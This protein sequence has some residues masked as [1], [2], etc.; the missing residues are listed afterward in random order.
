MKILKKIRER[1]LHWFIETI[2]LKITFFLNNILYYFFSILPIND[3][4]IIFESEGDLSDNSFALYDYMLKNNY[5]EKYKFIWAVDDIKNARKFKFPQTVFINRKYGVF[6]LKR[7]YYL[8]TSR[9][10]IFDHYNILSNVKKRRNQLVLNLWH[11]VGYKAIKNGK[12]VKEKSTFDFF[13]TLSDK[14]SL[15]F[16]K[17][18][19]E[20]DP[21]KGVVLGYPRLDYFFRDNL[22]G[23]KF[24]KSLVGDKNKVLLWMPTFRQSI[25][26]ELSEEYDYSETGLPIV[27]TADAMIK[28]NDY[29]IKENTT[30]I[31]KIHHLQAKLPIFKTEF[32]NIILMSD[33]DLRDNNVQLYQFISQ[34]DGLITDYSSIAIDYLLLDRPIIFTL[35]DYEEYEKHRG[36]YKKDIK[37]Y[38]PGEQVYN[39]DE[40]L[41]AIKNIIDNKDLYKE[42]RTKIL[43]LYH[44]FKDGESSSRVL[45][46]LKIER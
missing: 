46:F 26:P 3:R 19:L 32:S 35:D 11:G 36:F 4:K 41:I 38:M 10:I 40:F 31:L 42:D 45:K 14:L 13:D 15:E 8:A 33:G 22:E 1:G 9:Y 2:K 29:L 37:K 7:A 27:Y 21:S 30:I 25:N 5:T 34:M 12:K 44:K 18:F 43:P 16:L 39:Y 24:V 23:K 6:D 20:C 28:L 17:D